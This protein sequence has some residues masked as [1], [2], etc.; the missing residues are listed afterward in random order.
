MREDVLILLNEREPSKLQHAQHLQE[1]LENRELSVSRVQPEQELISIIKQRS[2]RVLVL[3]YLL[4]DF[5]TAIEVLNGLEHEDISCLLWTDES[6]AHVAV[7][8]M[9]AGSKDFIEIGN[10][11]SL[12]RV[13]AAIQELLPETEARLPK[14][15]SSTLHSALP[16]IPAHSLPAREMMQRA[17]VVASG[18]KRI[19]ILFGA[20]GAGRNTLARWIHASRPFSAHYHQI[21]YDLWDKPV[22]CILGNSAQSHDELLCSDATV[23]IDHVTSESSELIHSAE[24][25]SKGVEP[26]S[27]SQLLLGTICPDTARAWQRICGAER[28]DIPSLSERKEDFL[29]Y[30]QLATQLIP[31][32][33]RR[34]ELLSSPEMIQALSLLDWPGNVREL[35]ATL[36]EI[37]TLDTDDLDEFSLPLPTALDSLFES[38]SAAAKQM[39]VIQWSKTLWERNANPHGRTVTALECKNALMK[40]SGNERIAAAM[41]GT[42]ISTLRTSLQLRAQTGES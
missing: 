21:E 19:C 10:S 27:A 7:S 33:L 25:W 38:D 8:A 18:C 13:V 5:G 11:R 4:G 12:E 17:K 32:K 41:L 31:K 16:S 6:S 14:K 28:I 15:F 22:S 3:D 39:R 2:P 24:A 29:P 37:I 42:S 9:R 40:S 30:M 36:S 20:T 35:L 26:S 23:F 1:Q 34:N